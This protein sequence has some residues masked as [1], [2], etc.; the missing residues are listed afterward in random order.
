MTHLIDEPC[1]F[2]AD[3]NPIGMLG[4]C[5][6][7]RG[8]VAAHE[9]DALGETDLCKRMYQDM[10]FAEAITFS[11]EMFAAAD[12][13]ER[14]YAAK[15]EKPKGAGWNGTYDSEKKDWVW[16]THSTFE[17]AL[18]AIRQAARW[19]D[20]VGRLGFGVNAWY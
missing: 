19:Y 7:L 20:K 13:L 2:A 3:D 1:P 10:S 11:A 5:C 16:N 18:A 8:K 14:E 17:E 6:S 9:L 4:T 15:P 12:R